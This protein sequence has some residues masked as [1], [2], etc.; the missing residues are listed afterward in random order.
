MTQPEP[1]AQSGTTD[2][3]SGVG[4]G[5]SDGTGTT[6]I[7]PTQSGGT[8]TPP[9]DAVSDPR[10]AE[11]AAMRARMQ[12][13]DRRASER[14]AEL[15]Q[16]R[17]KDL[18]EA[19][20]LKRDYE[21]TLKALESARGQNRELAVGNTFL[22]E[23]TYE[24]HDPKAALNMLDRSK[25]EVAEDGTVTGMKVALK[26]LAEANPWM[27]KPKTAEGG[28]D[29]PTKVGVPPIN[30]GAAPTGKNSQDLKTRFPGLRARLG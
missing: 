28:T 5:G 18:P 10:E 4:N 30:G 26:A 1:G 23:N 8:A 7:D 13:A 12:A 25:V 17:D 11:I 3:Q 9:A 24:W 15:K 27:L 6:P 14:E 20:K 21:E 2:P 16:L 22:M 19:E 29:G